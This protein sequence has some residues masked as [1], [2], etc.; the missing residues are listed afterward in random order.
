MKN[1][2]YAIALIFMVLSAVFESYVFIF[3]FVAALLAFFVEQY[4]TY[5]F[6]AGELNKRITELETR[7]SKFVTGKGFQDLRKF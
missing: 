7:V 5:T 4:F 3:G 6:Q 2:F 1:H